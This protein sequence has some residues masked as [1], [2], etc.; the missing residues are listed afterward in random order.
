MSLSLK[1][2][3]VARPPPRQG[4]AKMLLWK[5]EAPPVHGDRP[6]ATS[7]SGP[8]GE[9]EQRSSL[10]RALEWGYL[11]GDHLVAFVDHL[12]EALVTPVLRQQRYAAG[13]HLFP[14]PEGRRAGLA[15]P[16]DLV[17]HHTEGPVEAVVRVGELG[18]PLGPCPGEDQRHLLVGLLEL[19]GRS[20]GVGHP[21][22]VRARFGIRH[23]H[24]SHLRHGVTPLCS[25]SLRAI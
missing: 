16:G 18:H 4:Q 3:Y 22:R 7:R 8:R 15:G 2:E 25:R 23:D 13:L 11:E 14:H 6:T 24:D 1:T 17:L 5:T 12:P 9:W 10:G 19:V 21:C 20:Q